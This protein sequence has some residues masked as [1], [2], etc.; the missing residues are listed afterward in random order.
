MRTTLFLIRHAAT[1][2]N[3]MTPARLQG[4]RTDP[5]LAP[6]GLRQAAVTRDGFTVG[7]LAAV[8]A[9]GSPVM[10]GTSTLW[11]WALEQ[12]GDLGHQRPPQP[13]QL[14]LDYPDD[15]KRP[16]EP[17]A[18]TTIAIVA[19]DIA[20]TPSQARRVAVMAHDGFARSL[21][22][23][24]TPVDGDIVF[25]ISTG[26]K[27]LPEPWQINLGRIGSIAADCVA[28]AV[29]RGVFEAAA[30]GRFVSYRSIHA[31]GF[32]QQA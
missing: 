30:L 20:L 14:S 21:R 9:F 11:A 27:P 12:N 5:D 2:A 19:T 23:V 25:A 6:V 4:R 1:A 29:A 28:R 26:A 7:A 8:N 22:P 32:K 13:R 10:P 3:L 17:A 31:A 24:H 16:P 15:I 18:N